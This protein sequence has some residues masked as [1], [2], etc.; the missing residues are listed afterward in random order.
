MIY[1]DAAATSLQKPRAVASSSAWAIRNLASPGRGGHKAAMYAADTAFACR[2][3]LV[4]LF[5][6]DNPEKVIFTM[7]ATHALNI[8]LHSAVRVGDRVVISGYEHNAV[9]RPLYSLGAEVVV[10]RSPLFDEDAALEAFD[11]AL[12]GADLCVCNHVSNVFGFILPLRGIAKLCEKYGVTLIVDASQS[13]GALDIDF[14]A[15]GAEY[16]AMP[17]HKGLF[18]PQGTGVL[19]CRDSALPLMQGGTGS[20]SACVEM[21]EEL[22]DRLE[23]GTHNVAGIAGLLQGVRFVRA[24]GTPRILRHERELCQNLASRL[25]KLPGF[26]VF[27]AGIPEL[28]AG[29]LSMR[30]QGISCETFAE[31]LG[32]RDVA[33]RAGL[34]C[35]P[36]AHRTAGTI[37]TGTV[38]FS[39]SPFNYPAEIAKTA[40]MVGQIAAAR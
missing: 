9:T 34:H 4:E 20:N 17:G 27:R 22:P 8:A 21:P 14:P 3:E 38:R 36:T 25:S 7:N 12:P 30:C 26:E 32:E 2:S 35:A 11:R 16:M 39:F 37:D 13:A 19:L 1:L 40:E 6:M 31:K 10:A 18:G 28:Q 15:L 5:H 29:V 23:A 24:T 33:V